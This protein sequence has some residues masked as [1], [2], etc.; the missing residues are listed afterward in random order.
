MLFKITPCY[1]LTKEHIVELETIDLGELG[2]A[3]A[4]AINRSPTGEAVIER[5]D[6]VVRIKKPSR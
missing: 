3:V 6:D 2:M 5:M 4:E 1:P